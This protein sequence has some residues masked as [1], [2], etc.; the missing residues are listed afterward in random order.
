MKTGIV[1]GLAVFL[2][3]AAF[4]QFRSVH[5]VPAAAYS[6]IIIHGTPVCVFQADGKIFARV[7]ECAEDPDADAATPPPENGPFTGG[8]GAIL[9]PGHPPIDADPG[10]GA[11]RRIPI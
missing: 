3:A 7:G 9:P 4:V 8:G 1:L 5:A 6:Q 10:P 11:L 2:L